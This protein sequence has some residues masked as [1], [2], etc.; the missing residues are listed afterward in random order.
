MILLGAFALLGLSQLIFILSDIDDFF[1]MADII[2]LISYVGL[3]ILGVKILQYG[4]KKEPNGD[5]IRH[6]GDNTRKKRKH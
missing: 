1:V 4:K 3:L 5:N 2:E 6:A